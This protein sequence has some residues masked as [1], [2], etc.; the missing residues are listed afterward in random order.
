MR[1]QDLAA[2]PVEVVRGGEGL[3]R[4]RGGFTGKLRLSADGRCR[5]L[6]L[7]VT[8]GRRAD[9]TRF[10]PALEKIRVPR[11]GLSRPRKKPGSLA[12]AAL[13]IRLRS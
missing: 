7:I 1:W 10:T 3:G 8:P 13:A 9:C 6:S 12:V 4:S 2:R 11:S 5:L